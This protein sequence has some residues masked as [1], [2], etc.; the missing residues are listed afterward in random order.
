MQQFEQTFAAMR[1]RPTCC[2][3]SET[4]IWEL[5]LPLGDR[6][7]LL[8]GV[9]ALRRA[10]RP[11]RGFRLPRLTGI[12]ADEGERRQGDRLLRR[13]CRLHRP[14]KE[15]GAEE[16]HELLARFFETADRL[17]D[18]HGG[19]VDKHIGTVSWLFSARP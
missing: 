6:L 16:I 3:N 18:D 19:S 7:R 13:H 8:E 1:S 4:S 9:A 5:G 11:A 2:R 17:I 10:D 12:R 15:L 14:Y